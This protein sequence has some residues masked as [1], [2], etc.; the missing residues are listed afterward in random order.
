MSV[1]QQM[2]DMLELNGGADLARDMADKI[3]KASDA[4]LDSAVEEAVSEGVLAT[5]RDA[6][7]QVWINALMSSPT[8]HVANQ[9][10]N[11]SV[12]L[13][14]VGERKPAGSHQPT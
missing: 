7:L 6:F 4:G 8:T 5:S 14:Q 3:V 12:A 1:T 13:M 9:L 11:L 2:A 10:S